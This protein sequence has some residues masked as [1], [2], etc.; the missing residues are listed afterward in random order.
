MIVRVVNGVIISETAV[1]G[2]RP[3]ALREVQEKLYFLTTLDYLLIILD[4]I[5]ITLGIVPKTLLQS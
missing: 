2:S 5:L 3:C 4:Y 1:G